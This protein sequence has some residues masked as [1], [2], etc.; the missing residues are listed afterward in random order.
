MLTLEEL[1]RDGRELR[2]TNDNPSL[3]GLRTDA[4]PTGRGEAVTQLKA[5]F[6]ILAEDVAAAVTLA[7]T[8]DTQFARRTLVRTLLAFVE[9]VVNQLSSVSVASAPPETHIFS[10]QELAALR[11]ETFDVSEKGEVRVRS[12]KVPLKPRI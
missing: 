3:P 5:T 8:E 9:G 4:L 6:K 12:A 10:L 7:K 11:A 2:M 1:N